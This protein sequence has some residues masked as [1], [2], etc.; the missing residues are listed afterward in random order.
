MRY[1]AAGAVVLSWLILTFYSYKGASYFNRIYEGP[2]WLYAVPGI[3]TG[4]FTVY[5]MAT[6]KVAFIVIRGLL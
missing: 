4:F 6:S 5:V 1:A 2:A 3:I